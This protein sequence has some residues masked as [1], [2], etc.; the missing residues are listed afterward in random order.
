M[1]VQVTKLGV[2]VN[3][4]VLGERHFE[5][6]KEKV[7]R[8]ING[9]PEKIRDKEITKTESDV[10]I[11][12]EQL[13]EICKDVLEINLT[14]EQI[15]KQLKDT[16]PECYTQGLSKKWTAKAITGFLNDKLKTNIFHY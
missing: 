16:C 5:Q 11:N 2:K 13:K 12:I 15:N 9:R 4:I 3:G 7:A 8:Y 10:Y 1:K 14:Q 6:T